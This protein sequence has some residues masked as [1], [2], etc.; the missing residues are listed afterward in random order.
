MNFQPVHIRRIILAALLIIVLFTGSRLRFAQKVK[1]VCEITPLEVWC[2]ARIGAGQLSA[3][4]QR[5]FFS[6]GGK[7]ILA[8]FDR[9][10]FV[11]INLSRDLRDG[12]L[13][14][15]GDTI[16]VISSYY[17]QAEIDVISAEIEKA[18]RE[19]TALISGSRFADI[20]VA[21]REL[22]ATEVELRSYETE[23]N[24]AQALYDSGYIADSDYRLIAGNWD[25]LKAQVDV[26]KA[27]LEAF[28]AGGRP[29]DIEVASAEIGRLQ[30]VYD[31]V[32]STKE[33]LQAILAPLPG[34]IILGGINGEIVR[35]ERIDT[36]GVAIAI[37]EG[38]LAR[39]QDNTK[40][41]I[42]LH[43]IDTEIF[44]INI[45]RTGFMRENLMSGTYAIGLLANP[46]KKIT[47]GMRGIA[48]I[49]I[50]ELTLLEML[51]MRLRL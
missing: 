40:A 14:H 21:K 24:R 42:D 33:Q 47:P 27:N 28:Q 36:V 15:A 51:K 8:Q 49:P 5:N 10:D 48:K 31:G 2:L 37:S 12:S 11:E 34:R 32:I 7:N 45:T 39:L 13:V 44:Q 4:W 18:R 3:G 41:F 43:A 25:G 9:P 30:R 16:A 38:L 1:G 29:E 20:E 23:M 22:Q 19:R 6:T 50:Q 17:T 46:H 35:I 26:A